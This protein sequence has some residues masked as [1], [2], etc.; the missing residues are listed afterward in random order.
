[1]KMTDW[2]P[3]EIKPVYGG[4]YEIQT[5]AKSLPHYAVWDGFFWSMQY[6]VTILS[7]TSGNPFAPQNL[8]WRGWTQKLQD[9]VDVPVLNF[10]RGEI[11]V[12]AGYQGT[13]GLLRFNYEDG[14]HQAGDTIVH[15]VPLEE[16]AVILRF[17]NLKGIDTV[18]HCLL[19]T[20]KLMVAAQRD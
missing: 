13:T 12:Q 11:G 3:P 2:F 17:E 14:T 10:G 5:A 15:L 19:E 20:R 18:L 16:Y 4:I 8:V 6:S 7:V 9:S 1:M